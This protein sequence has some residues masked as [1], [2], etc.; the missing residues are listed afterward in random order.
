MTLPAYPQIE[1]G[2]IRKL[3]AALSTTDMAIGYRWPRHGNALDRMR[4]AAFHG[5]VNF[6]TGA[7]L[8]DLGCGVRAMRRQ[9]LEEIDLYGD[10]HR[11]LPILAMR[12]GFR[13]S[14]VSARQSAQDRHG[15]IYRPREYM[16]H[17]LDL[18]SIFFLMRFTKKPLRFFGMLG[19]ATFGVGAVLIAYLGIDRVLFSEPLADRPALLL[20]ALLLVLGMQ[21]FALGL[22]GELIIFTHARGLK[23]HACG[24]AGCY[25]ALHAMELYAE[26][27]DAAGALD[28][29][30]A[31]ASFNGPAFYGLPRNTGTITLRKQSW[32]PPESF[33]FGEA[34]LKPL[35]SGEA[36]PWKLVG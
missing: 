28:K 11:F 15:R 3:L 16:H 17:L 1:P 2:D 21:V 19:A 29:L 10:Q 30:E 27:F 12:L 14:E 4:R 6:V 8:R 9:V 36:L 20:A 31:F 22:L 33:A 5:L 32:T 18:F 23:E 24:C 34:E 13:V 35:R 7:R 26:A 25:T